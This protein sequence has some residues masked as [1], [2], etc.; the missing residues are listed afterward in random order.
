[1][2]GAVVVLTVGELPDLIQDTIAGAAGLIAVAVLTWMLFWMRR[3]G[4]ALKGDLERG[5]DFAVSDGSI[6]ALAGLAF[7]A[8]LREGLETA[9]FMFAILKSSGTELPTFVGAILG[10]VIA[11]AVG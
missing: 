4:R 1:M 8:V 6:L 5:V 3:Q 9:L 10:L 11:G 2:A 7:V